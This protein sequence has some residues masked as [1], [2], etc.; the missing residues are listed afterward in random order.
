MVISREHFVLWRQN[1][2][3][4]KEKRKRAL[5]DIPQVKWTWKTKG[6]LHLWNIHLL[7]KATAGLTGPGHE[8]LLGFDPKGII[9]ASILASPSGNKTFLRKR[10]RWTKEI[11][12]NF[13]KKKDMQVGARSTNCSEWLRSHNT[14]THLR[15]SSLCK[16]FA[17]EMRGG[18]FA[19]AYRYAN[20]A[21]LR[22]GERASLTI[23]QR[24][25]QQPGWKVVDDPAPPFLR[26]PVPPLH[27]ALQES[28][29]LD[30]PGK[31]EWIHPR[32]IG[33][34]VWDD[35]SGSQVSFAESILDLRV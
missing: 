35:T 28:P 34:L 24:H 13:Y 21:P 29:P 3:A 31:G 30:A 14:L 32:S 12:V 33:R 2:L 17:N 16:A 9:L 10:S 5:V 22:F 18:W 25:P 1:S 8:A 19:Y 6:G 23:F 15:V 7:S 26:Q 11:R 4:A 20:K 27:A